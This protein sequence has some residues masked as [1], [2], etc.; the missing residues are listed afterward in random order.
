MTCSGGA[1]LMV[2]MSMRILLTILSLLV[3]ALLVL[4]IMI[5]LALPAYFA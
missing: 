1:E 3:K 4:T 5:V 2:K